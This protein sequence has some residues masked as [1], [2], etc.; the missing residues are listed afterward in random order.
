MVAALAPWLAHIVARLD[1][2]PGHF[3]GAVGLPLAACSVDCEEVT[4]Q[5]RSLELPS[6][7]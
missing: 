3:G 2:M 5:Q 4:I 7:T 6:R 1:D